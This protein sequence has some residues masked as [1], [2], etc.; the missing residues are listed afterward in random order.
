MCSEYFFLNH[1]MYDIDYAEKRVEAAERA[2][3]RLASSI[4]RHLIDRPK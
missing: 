4:V 3:P 2:G 1:N